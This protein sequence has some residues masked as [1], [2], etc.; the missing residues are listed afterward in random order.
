VA[1]LL[2]VGHATF[3]RYE[4]EQHRLSLL[5]GYAVRER[6]N[7][8]T[9]C[10]VGHGLVG[11][12][13]IER[14]PMII[15]KPPADYIIITSALGEAAPNTIAVLPVLLNE[16]LVA[17]LE[18]ATFENFG[19][20][21][22]ALLDGLLPILALSMEI[23]ERNTR[24][25]EL[26]EEARHQAEN[27]EKQA[28]KLEEQ[29]VE[30]EA[31][32]H[33]IKATEAWFRSIVESA[34]DGMLVVDEQGRIILTNQQVETIFGYQ[35][36]ELFGCPVETLVPQELRVRHAA[37][38]NDYMADE[39]AYNKATANRELFGVR[40]DGTEFPV[41]VNLSRLPAIGG[42]GTCVCA[43]VRDISKRNAQA[44]MLET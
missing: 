31:Q 11:Q 15:T 39:L 10:P 9:Y 16:Q 29:T 44:E 12:C 8:D 20:N 30:M 26:L 13:A 37:L 27:M 1:P 2:K 38:R 17:V 18:L 7:L 28:A 41:E 19:A 6:N 14:K 3:Y 43:S 33:E 4:E 42:R 21:E 32:Q 36:G 35:P 25:Q 23:M 40:K 24:T 34:S 5:G 22:Q